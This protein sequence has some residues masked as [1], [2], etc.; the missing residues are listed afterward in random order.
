VKLS[1]PAKKR[2]IKSFA[3][4]HRGMTKLLEDFVG[5]VGVDI[6][7]DFGLTAKACWRIL[8][9]Q[10]DAAVAIG[11]APKM[12]EL[13]DDQI[14]LTDAVAIVSQITQFDGAKARE[15]IA[16][17]TNEGLLSEDSR[18]VDDDWID[19]VRLPYQ[20]FSDHLISRHLLA[21]HLDTTSAATIRKCF[22]PTK[23]LGRIFKSRRWG[24]YEMPGLVSAVMLE[25]PERVKRAVHPDRQ[26]LAYYIPRK[27]RTYALSEPFIE[28]LLWRDV[29]S[30]S[31]QTDKLVNAFLGAPQRE[32][33]KAMLEALVSLASRPE[34]RYRA[35][36]LHG[37]LWGMSVPD[38]DLFWTEF[39]RSHS[40]SAA[41]YRVLDWVQQPD[42]S[43]MEEGT[44]KNLITLISLFLT[45]TVRPFR[46]RATHCL[47]L[48]GER[49]PGSLFAEASRSFAFNDPYVRERML[50]AAYGVLMR[51]WAIS[52]A[53][54]KEAALPL[55]L[56]L[57][58]RLVGTDDEAPIEHMLMRDYARGFIELTAKLLPDRADEL[59]RDA[60]PV[61]PKTVLRRPSRISEKSV[62]GA[63]SA[64]HMDF[65][66]YTMGR[67]V[68]GRGNYDYDH[69]GYR[70]VRRQIERRILHLGYDAERFKTI[71]R[72]VAESTFYGRQS[73]DGQKTDR[74]GK[75]YSWIAY[76][77]VAGRLALRGRLPDRSE[78]RM[79]DTD[80]DPSFP[81]A[82]LEWKPPL[83]DLFT[84]PFTTAADWLQHGSS[85][86]YRDL[87]VLDSVEDRE[88][89]WV[90]L[91][92]YLSE[93]TVRDHRQ[94][95]TFLR[96][97]FV[98]PRDIPKL[99]A[100]VK[101]TEYPGNRA[102][103]EPHEEYYLFAGEIGWSEKY[104]RRKPG[105]L[106][107]PDVDEAFRGHET[108]RVTK[109][110]G[111]LNAFEQM[112]L[113]GRFL[114]ILEEGEAVPEEKAEYAPD[115]LVT[116]DEYE[117]IPGVKVE[118][119]ARHFSWE[120][121]HSE[122]NQSSGANYPSPA[123][124]DRLALRKRGS[125][126]DLFDE[127]GRPATMYRVFDSDS[128]DS[129]GRLLYLRADLVRDYMR[130]RGMA[131]VWINWGERE[132]HHSVSEGL[133]DDPKVQALWGKHTH[134][135]NEFFVYDPST[136]QA[137]E[138][139]F[140]KFA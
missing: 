107:R 72:I 74:Y 25:F 129:R 13:M 106:A 41:A 58:D 135:H 4:G 5:Q 10:G 93:G 28:G 89:P 34:H 104:G 99:H 82:P 77:E 32:T 111:D 131:L 121:Y 42:S 6:E 96:G 109:R 43:K 88:G 7:K 37:Y 57:R 81:A 17:M 9:G 137:Q 124:V 94:T 51:Q 117:H 62:K 29:D 36:K 39:L 87:L 3:S 76:F 24:G 52:P 38:R 35:E 2:R 79:S 55:A 112:R 118:V 67:L 86:D 139:D 68:S 103:P 48:L 21:R 140:P 47:V 22:R 136:G 123:L 75:K 8:K 84:A 30:F 125:Q 66:N 133:R 49:S 63:D 80:I 119:P 15:L 46:D 69:K 132:M 78:V 97:N 130:Q 116:V 90:L 54:L 18:Y 19:T 138:A 64:I 50:A 12:A 53:G 20:R 11:I 70:A 16:R 126:I 65:G 60:R 45:S 127:N 1:Q 61:S 71:D 83:Q 98:S 91:E 113:S 92:G 108:R 44:A 115:D 120:R 101:N 85:P 114:V 128:P 105:C 102:I 110:Y 33:Q 73:N 95:F 122:E 56:E 23:P 31:K 40:H 26:E 14:L 134:I 59:L 27:L 100:A